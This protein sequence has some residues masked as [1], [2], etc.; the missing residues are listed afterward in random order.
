MKA[1]GPRGG[2]YPWALALIFFAMVCAAQVEVPL[3]VSEVLVPLASHGRHSALAGGE[4]EPWRYK[5]QH[6]A[7]DKV[8]Q[9]RLQ[10]AMAQKLQ[11]EALYA[12]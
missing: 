6:A 1:L 10:M 7:K 4:A 12:S 9:A 3:E 2:M 5:M 8:I 11:D